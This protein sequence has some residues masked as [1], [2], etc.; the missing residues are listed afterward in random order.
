LPCRPFTHWMTPG[1]YTFPAKEACTILWPPSI[2]G[3]A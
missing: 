1:P 2:H 3:L